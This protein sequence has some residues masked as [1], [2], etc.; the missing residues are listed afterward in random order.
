MVFKIWFVL[1][2][3]A[4][5]WLSWGLFVPQVWFPPSRPPQ[6]YSATSRLLL[7]IEQALLEARLESRF[8]AGQDIP[9]KVCH[10]TE[11]ACDYL[12]RGEWGAARWHQQQ[13]NRHL[14]RLAD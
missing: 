8:Q 13:A 6:P 10:D 1:S 7:L 3:A 14:D 4:A 11:A 5:A 12:D 2:L 9:E